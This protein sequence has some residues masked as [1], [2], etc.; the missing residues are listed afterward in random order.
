MHWRDTARFYAG[1][2]IVSMGI[3]TAFAMKG[4]WMI[5]P[6]AGLEMAAL[7]IALYVVARR[8]ASWQE[9]AI[10]T[11]RVRVVDHS[12][13]QVNKLSFQRAWARVVLEEA[14]ISGHPSRLLLGSHGRHVEIGNC[15]NEEEKRHL[16]VQLQRAIEI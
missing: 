8:A 10:E 14:A 1:I 13:K 9:I 2:V 7:G 15:L 12:V 3:A 4:A 11:D 6:F 16:V 5:L